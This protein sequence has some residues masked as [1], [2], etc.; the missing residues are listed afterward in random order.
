MIALRDISLAYDDVADLNLR[1][2]G[3]EWGSMLDRL[4]ARVILPGTL[5]SIVVGLRLAL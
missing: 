5:P 2:W 1:V 3:D 4:K